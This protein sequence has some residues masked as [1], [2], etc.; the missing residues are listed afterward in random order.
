MERHASALKAAR[1]AVKRNKRN[2]ST[3]ANLRTAVKKVRTT[4]TSKAKK[5]ELKKTLPAL[6]NEAQRALM[7]A[8]SRGLIKK[9]NASRQ[10]ARLSA[11]IHKTLNA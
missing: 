8:A 10:V 4:L 1:Q 2:T 11:A 3:R 9:G 6:L 7:K 5:E